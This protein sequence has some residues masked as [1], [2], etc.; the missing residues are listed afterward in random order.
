MKERLYKL[1]LEGDKEAARKLASEALRS[2]DNELL[3]EMVTL[4]YKPERLIIYKAKP[5][6]E[7]TRSKIDYAGLVLQGKTVSE[8]WVPDSFENT[9]RTLR[10]YLTTMTPEKRVETLRNL[11][12][13]YCQYCG[14]DVPYYGSCHCEND[15]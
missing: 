5:S 15:E 4:L 2:N 10:N 3:L 14:R 11:Q 1:A 7:L 9:M 8:P 13:G 12:E 6:L